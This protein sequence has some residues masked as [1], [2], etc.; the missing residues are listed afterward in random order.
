MIDLKR[1]IDKEKEATLTKQAEELDMIK[2][3]MRTQAV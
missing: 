3:Q 1:Q 2:K